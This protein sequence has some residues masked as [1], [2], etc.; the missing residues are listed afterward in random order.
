M[1][2]FDLPYQINFMII[3][4]D[5]NVSLHII[6]CKVPFDGGRLV[7]PPVPAIVL[8]TIFYTSATLMVPLAI[9]RGIFAGGFLGYVSYDM[10]HY[11]LHHGSPTPGSYLHRLK[12][13]HVSHH[14]EDQQKGGPKITLT[15]RNINI[16]LF[17][18]QAIDKREK[19]CSHSGQFKSGLETVKLTFAQYCT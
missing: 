11:Y 7:F 18:V 12:K 4:Q 15:E 17:K 19:W 9:A 2:C 13:Y 5:Y 3:I 8:A 16:S 14:F 6:L 10:M 1:V